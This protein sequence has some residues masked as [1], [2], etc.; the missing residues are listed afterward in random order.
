MTTQLW[1]VGLVVFAT[2]LG[3]MGPILL[4][5]GAKDFNLNPLKQIKN[6]NMLGGIAVYALATIFF[7]PALKGGELSVLYPLVSVAYI[8]TTLLAML[9]LKEKMNLMKWMGIAIIILGVSLIGL[10]A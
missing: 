7:I 2:L 9:V 4:K 3:A 10:G 8:W 6:Y 1:A 5:K